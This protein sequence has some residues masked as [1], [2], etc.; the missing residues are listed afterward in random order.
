MN[1]FAKIYN[2]ISLNLSNYVNSFKNN[3]VKSTVKNIDFKNK[4]IALFIRGSKDVIHFNIFDIF[5]DFTLI[6]SLSSPSSFE[7]GYFCGINF[8]HFS[9]TAGKKSFDYSLNSNSEKY[10]CSIIYMDRK[11]NIVFNYV[12]QNYTKE[13]N[14]SPWEIK[15]R[16]GLIKNFHPIQ[17]C[18]IGLIAGCY[19]EKYN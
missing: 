18:Y 13:F 8:S 6:S 7:I 10:C 12:S 2:F 17:A 15:N 4:K 14:M 1:K 19:K 5:Y 9:K 3:M 11:K 16:K